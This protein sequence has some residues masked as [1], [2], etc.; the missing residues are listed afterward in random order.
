MNVLI[1]TG[2]T[3]S[4]PFPVPRFDG[5][6]P[7]L[8]KELRD[9]VRS[10]RGLWLALTATPLMLI[11]TLGPKIGEVAAQAKGRPIPPGL[12]FDPTMNVLIRWPQWIWL[13]AILAGMNL[14]I[15][16]RDRGTLAWS[17]SKPLSRGGLFLAKW[18]AG[19]LMFTVFG[20]VIPMAASVAAAAVAYGMPDLPTVAIGTLLLIATPAFYIAL[21]LA[22]STKLPSPAGVAGVG[23]GM[24]LAPVFLGA[25]L[26]SLAAMV[27][28][29]IAEWAVAM[30]LGLPASVITAVA[31]L[32]ATIALSVLGAR[33]LRAID[34]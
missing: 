30:A 31:W 6:R 32:I 29:S 9:W 2:T 14:L 26:P 22:V 4:R 23:I 15:S 17:L 13:F 12:D 33:R 19:V 27:P 28:T 7:F 21:A 3:T 20:I 8:A 25:I 18:A 10:R 11:S 5:A 34:L 24:A 1:A 16:E